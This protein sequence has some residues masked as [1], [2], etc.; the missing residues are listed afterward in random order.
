A[1]DAGAQAVM[2]TSPITPGISQQAIIDHYQ[3][4]HDATHL[5]IF[6][7]NEAGLSGNEK[8]FATLKVIAQLP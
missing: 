4:V 3:T 1:Q 7:N 6:M 2:F 5:D 8:S